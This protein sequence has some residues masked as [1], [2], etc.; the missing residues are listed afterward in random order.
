L[1][2]EYFKTKIER[3]RTLRNDY[4]VAHYD[5]DDKIEQLNQEIKMAT[6]VAKEVIEHYISSLQSP[7]E[8]G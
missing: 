8:P 5:L 4:G 2:Y 1:S 7:T 6:T 3:V